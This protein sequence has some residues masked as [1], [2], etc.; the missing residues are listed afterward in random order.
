MLTEKREM[1][2]KGSGGGLRERG[3]IEGGEGWDGKGEEELTSTVK[4]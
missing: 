3:K 4:I 1:I 2:E